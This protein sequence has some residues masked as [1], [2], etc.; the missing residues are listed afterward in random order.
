[1]NSTQAAKAVKL[2]GDKD[3]AVYALEVSG[4]RIEWARLMVDRVRRNRHPG[5]GEVLNYTK[6]R[7]YDRDSKV[8]ILETGNVADA[9]AKFNKIAVACGNIFA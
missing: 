1:M 2:V 5:R 6:A 3:Y 7:I 8:T 9:V 4:V